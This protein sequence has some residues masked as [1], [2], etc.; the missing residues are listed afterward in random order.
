MMMELS[1][2][3]I[4]TNTNGKSPA[5]APTEG[6]QL[7]LPYQDQDQNAMT[8]IH[9]EQPDPTTTIPAKDG[10]HDATN[11]HVGGGDASGS[12]AEDEDDSVLAVIG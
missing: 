10:G 9:A 3:D 5:T 8:D 11:Q 6:D 1:A 7:Q 12:E 4:D 2:K